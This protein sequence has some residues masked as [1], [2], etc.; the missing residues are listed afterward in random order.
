M[1]K[2]NPLKWEPKPFDLKMKNDLSRNYPYQRI[3]FLVYE[4]YGSYV[5]EIEGD[6]LD[7]IDYFKL[8]D[9]YYRYGIT[10]EDRDLYPEEFFGLG[11]PFSNKL[12]VYENFF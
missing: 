10:F 6:I 7:E 9:R 8:L 12:Y 5:D 4:Y 1:E 11:I 2:F 3:M